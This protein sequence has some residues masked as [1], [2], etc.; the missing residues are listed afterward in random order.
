MAIPKNAAVQFIR[1]A[2]V[3]KSAKF[4]VCL[5]YYGCTVVP[6]NGIN[7]T[8]TYY[9]LQSKWLKVMYKG[10]EGYVQEIFFSQYKKPEQQ[11]FHY[12]EVIEKNTVR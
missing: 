6:A 8:G 3:A 10:K 11:N 1:Y 2:D 5:G 9:L 4:S 12:S 7:V